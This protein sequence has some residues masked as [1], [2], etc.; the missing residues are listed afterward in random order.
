[1][2]NDPKTG[3]KKT[4]NLN[5]AGKSKKIGALLA[6]FIMILSFGNVTA[7]ACTGVYIGK[8]VSTDGSTILARSN[9][10][11]G[12]FS[13]YLDIKER[14]ENSPGRSLPVGINQK[15][16]APLPSTTYRYTATPLMDAGAAVSEFNRDVAA[17]SNEYGV[18]MTMSV[19]AF[20]NKDAMKA[21]PWV[22]DGISED[23]ATELVICQ[24]KTAKEAVD[25]L[26]SLIDK[27]GSA[28]TNIA[29]IADQT[30]AWYVEMY[31]GH[32]YA[33]VKL[34][35][36]QV[37]V[38]GNEFSLEYLSD[39]EE[40]VTS[41]DLISLAE[42]NNFAVYGKNHEVNLY[43]TYAGSTTL[44]DYSHMRTWIGHQLLSSEYSDNY[45]HD[46]SYPLCFK[47][48]NKVSLEDV[49]SVM[50]NRYEGTEF[51]PDETGRTD[52]RVIGTDTS[53]SVHVLQ[54]FPELP[55]NM[56]CVTWECLGPAPYGVFVPM[57]NASKTVSRSYGRKQ[58]VSDKKV[59][60]DVHYPYYTYK[61]I[62]TL[63]VEKSTYE[64]YG[65]PVRHYWEMAEKGMVKGMSDVLTEASEMKDAD[66]AAAH[67]T[68]YCN[69]MQEQ[70]FEDA[71]N[72]LNDIKWY[73]SFNSNT[74]KNGRNP[75]TDEVYDSLAPVDPL[76]LSEDLYL[77][78]DAY[79]RR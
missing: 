44:A 47:P 19:T 64:T 20:S 55:A 3:M 59:F 13:T 71:R 22:E 1:M 6:V 24:S 40:S 2:F 51:S 28:E 62:N 11:Q 70:A 10:T 16:W 61:E 79:N 37:S 46:A 36:D 12:V 75:E 14:V 43:K 53:I 50:R 30:E 32:Q 45:D 35:D 9:D 57:S 8:D 42:K 56:S 77:N 27:Y 25:V 5:R 17:V 65:K 63:C 69:D 72:I 15:V 7:F 54:V 29:L 76:D 48:D 66:K 4:I 74:M 23:T 58:S 52:M 18:I 34:P 41:K 21:D 67:L 73:M 60:D 38:F 39:Y 26:T 78:I 31:N 68:D 49:F 33:A